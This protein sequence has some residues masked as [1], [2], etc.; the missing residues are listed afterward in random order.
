MVYPFVKCFENESVLMPL[1]LS[2]PINLQAILFGIYCFQNNHHN[3]LK[4]LKSSTIS[5]SNLFIE[6]AISLVT[7]RVY[8]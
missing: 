8:S 7:L 5:F 3:L 2:Y 6:C 4:L 1:E